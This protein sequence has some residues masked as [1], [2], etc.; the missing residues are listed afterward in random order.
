MS[1]PTRE[2][3]R[4]SNFLLALLAFVVAFVISAF[5]FSWL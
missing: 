3:S 2:K 5:V 1:T 4:L